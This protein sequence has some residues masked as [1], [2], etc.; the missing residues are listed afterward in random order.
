MLT[1]S[2][3]KSLMAAW[4]RALR[5]HASAVDAVIALVLFGASFPGTRISAP[6]FAPEEQWWPGVLITGLAALCLLWRRSHPRAVAVLTGAAGIAVAAL[7]YLPS[8]FVVGPL[9]VSL[10]TLAERTERRVANPIA[11]TAVVLVSAASVAAHPHETLDITLIAPAASLLLPLSLG[12]TVRIRRAYVQSV[13][14]RAQYAEQTREQEA[15]HR[16]AEERVRIARELHDVVAHHLALANAQAG[17]VA[18]LMRTRP[19]QAQK[20]VA[21]LAATTSS[22]LRE[23]KGTVG[24]LREADEPNAPLQPAPGLAQLP[25]LTAA[26]AAAG[27]NVTVT[28][29]GR[30]RPIS[31][32]ADLTAYRIIQEA[33]TNVTKHAA[34]GEAHVLLRYVADRLTVTVTNPARE[35]AVPGLHNTGFGLIGM[36][37]RAQSVGGAVRTGLRPD[38]VFEVAAD[39][40]L[41]DPQPEQESAS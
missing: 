27:L 5:E 19:E 3:R 41:Y 32:G 10:Y 38:G 7:G 39:L 14:A 25:E 34:T 40:P 12:T 23:L 29:E 2:G 20:L 33:L 26:M 17:A 18:H 22:A 28:T 13:Q 35:P 9:V 15:R 21:E 37:E 16:V 4:Q 30:A 24:L 36:R 1:V 6:G 8:I 11:F 31:P